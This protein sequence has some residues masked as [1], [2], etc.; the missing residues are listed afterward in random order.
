MFKL[1]S[2]VLAVVFLVACTSNKSSN[3]TESQKPTEIKKVEKALENQEI[4]HNGNKMWLGEI[5]E[6]SFENG[7]YAWYQSNKDNYE[8]NHD[9]VAEFAKDLKDYNIEIFMGTWCGDSKRETPNFFKILDAAN[10]PEDQITMYAVDTN[11]NTPSGIE[12]EKDVRYV[13]T[14]IFYKGG[15]E[16]GR[17]VESPMNSLEEDIRDIVAGNPQTPNYAE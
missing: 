16:V 10:F 4:D 3:S 6:Q 8:V 15:K 11:K 1:F 2:T 9:V 7:N 12:S 5:N 17:I 13:P 14:F